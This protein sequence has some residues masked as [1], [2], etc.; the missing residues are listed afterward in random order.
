MATLGMC[1]VLACSQQR[2]LAVLTERST[3]ASLSLTSDPLPE[4]K[5]DESHRDTVQAADMDGHRMVIMN[6]V[7][8]EDGEMV[9][10]D[11]IEA[12]TVTARFRNVAE[13][14]GKVGISFRITVPGSMR[15]AAWQ[16][17]LTPVMHIMGDT[18]RLDRVTVTGSGYRHRQLR[19]Y[20]RYNRFLSS[21]VSDSTL[22]IDM[23]QLELFIRRNIPDLYAFRNDSSA[24]SSEQFESAFG[25]TGKEAVE[26]YT[27][28]FRS[29][30]NRRRKERRERMF[31]KYVKVPLDNCGV[32]LDTVM[33]DN[34]APLEYDYLETVATRPGL[35][36]VDIVLKGEIF[37]QDRRI[38]VM[39]DSEPLTFY[40]SSLSA[41]ADNTIKYMTQVIERRVEANTSCYIEFKSASHEVD[42]LLG[43][44]PE[45]IARIKGN[46]A[47]LMQNDVYDL[48]SIVVTS[49]ASPEGLLK[50]NMELSSYRSEAISDY[51]SGWMSE[52]RDSLSSEMGFSIDESGKTSVRQVK[53]IPMVSRSGGEN[54]RM[55]DRL[56]ETDTLLSEADRQ[57]YRH[58][59][60]I[61]DPDRRERA[62]QDEPYYP[63]LR[64]GLYPK[65][66]TVR[67]DFHLHRKGMVKDTV[68]TTVIDS[69]YMDGVQAIRDRDYRKAVTL[70]RP[71]RDYNT[72][73][74]YLCLGY[75]ASA[76]KILEGMERTPQVMY[77]T[78]V[79]LARRGQD[80]MAYRI[81]LEACSVEPSLEHRGNLD[82]EI[83]ELKRRHADAA[84][85]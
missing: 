79:I 39:P 24:V 59:A 67:F 25:V 68:H 75:D 56:V 5:P 30:R 44:N 66:R 81:Y 18:V 73:V 2:Q 7:K 78:A 16:A 49:S 38:Y 19:G 76:M 69:A 48:D 62:M 26:H 13:R 17:R 8:D 57:S 63:R 54:W 27:D 35:R 22:F 70:L 60:S 9:A 85:K 84:G 42:P 6:A 31:S 74:A 14:A 28:R 41:F 23:R 32:R 64:Y 40:I 37:E 15:N 36:K 3:G 58:L 72:A 45:E 52:Y 10:T 11:V 50:Y 53:E 1:L 29:E 61:S 47:D 43:N 46:L 33:A 4:Q 51:F 20:E 65:L 71:Y 80:D 12:A 83:S 77:M 21:I 82:P 55:L 34:G